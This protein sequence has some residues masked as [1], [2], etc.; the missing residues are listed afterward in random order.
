VP[1]QA[2]N[3]YVFP[4]IG[5][6]VMA[7]GARRVT[8]EMFQAAAGTLAGL[9]TEASLARGTL[10]PPLRDIRQVS[11]AIAVEVAEVAYRAGLAS[12]PEPADLAGHIRESMY[13]PDYRSQA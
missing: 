7:V 5:L 1:G 4:G 10:F 9:T 12:M 13:E 3:A 6:G 8:E 11:H 2:N